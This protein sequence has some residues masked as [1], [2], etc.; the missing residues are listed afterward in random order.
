MIAERPRLRF[1]AALCRT[2]SDWEAGTRICAPYCQRPNNAHCF[3][4]SPKDQSSLFVESQTAATAIRGY[5]PAQ[6]SVSQGIVA[7]ASACLKKTELPRRPLA[8]VIARGSCAGKRV[9]DERPA[10]AWVASQG[11]KKCASAKGCEFKDAKEEG[12]AKPER[13]ASGGTGAI[14]GRRCFML[15]ALSAAPPPNAAPPRSAACMK[16]QREGFIATI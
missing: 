3:H 5:F 11:G 16:I 13:S 12:G 15:T 8:N 2:D 9:D 1:L 6:I 10:V 4:S 14:G 7:R